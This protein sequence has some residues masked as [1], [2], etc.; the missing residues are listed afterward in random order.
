MGKGTG[1]IKK[2]GGRLDTRE[3]N[4]EGDPSRSAAVVLENLKKSGGTTS[5]PAQMTVL[6]VNRNKG[7]N[8]RKGD[9]TA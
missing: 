4:R 1:G 5:E 8:T 6:A 7:V 9:N 3:E 2:R